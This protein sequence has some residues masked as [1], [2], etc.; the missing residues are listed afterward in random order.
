MSKL[1][2]L[3]TS[4]GLVTVVGTGLVVGTGAFDVSASTPHWDVTTKFLRMVR[5]RSIAVRSAEV[6]PPG[7]LEDRSQLVEGVVHFQ[8]HCAVCHGAPGVEPSEIAQG[9]YPP[10]PDLGRT[11]VERGPAEVFWIVKNGIKMSGMPA[12]GGHGDERLWPVVAL[13][14]KLPSMNAAAY[15]ELVAEAN[16]AGEGHHS[17]SHTAETSGPGPSAHGDAHRGHNHTHA[18]GRK[19]GNGT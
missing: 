15:A 8:S 11:A 3:V 9:M 4:A 14:S 19:A 16:R 18:H 1:W 13:T 5:D 6:I 2:P 7:N 12:W 10:P 17:H